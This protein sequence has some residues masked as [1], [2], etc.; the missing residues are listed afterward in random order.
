MYSDKTAVKHKKPPHLHRQSGH[1]TI[2][3]K[4]MKQKEIY[5]LLLTSQASKATATHPKANT[6]HAHAG[7][8]RESF[9]TSSFTVSNS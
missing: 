5:F 3:I 4:S 1:Y 6:H 8:S 2:N 9:L 7:T